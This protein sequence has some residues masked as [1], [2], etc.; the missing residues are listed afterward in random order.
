MSVHEGLKSIWRTNLS[1]FRGCFTSETKYALVCYCCYGTL[2]L[3][4]AMNEGSEKSTGAGGLF[5]Q[6]VAKR[7]N[8]LESFPTYS[9][10]PKCQK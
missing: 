3:S 5:A 9:Q 7:R 4:G 6:L 8:A 2:Y 1:F 10:L